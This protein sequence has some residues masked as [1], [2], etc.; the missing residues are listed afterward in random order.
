MP[1]PLLQDAALAWE[2]AGVCVL[3]A[4]ADG[5]KRP[6]LPWQQYQQRRASRDELA[7][8]FRG[9]EI[10]GIGLIC[11]QVS[12]GL[13][14]FEAEGAAVADGMH[15]A[16]R[17]LFVAAGLPDLWDKI[18]TYVEQSPAGGLHWIYRVDGTVPGNTK[19]ARRR[20]DGAVQVLFET[21][22][23]GGWVVCSP[24]AGRTHPTGKAWQILPGSTPGVIPTLTVDEHQTLHRLAM[25]FDV[26]ETFVAPVEPPASLRT[27][28]EKAP[29]DQ[30]NETTDWADILIP[31]GWTLVYTRGD[32]TRA[33][34]RPG[35]RVGISATTGFGDQGLDLLYVFTSSTQFDQE[36]SYSKLGAY[37]VLNTGGDFAK[38]ASELRRQGF[39]DPLPPQERTNPLTLIYGEGQGG[40]ASPPSAP[41]SP[42]TP[43][44]V[45]GQQPDEDEPA[46]AELD[47]SVH[48]DGTFVPL[49]PELMRRSDD[50]HLL[51]RGKVHSFHGESESGKSWIGLHAIAE[52]LKAGSRAAMIDFE[53][54][55]HTIVGRL[56][57]MGVE[58]EA[59]RTLFSYRHPDVNP[60]GSAREFQ[61][62]EKLLT[63]RY[64]IVLIDGITEALNVF[65]VTSKDNDEVTGW[66]RSVPRKLAWSTGAAVIM[67][68]HVT[69][70]ADSRGRFAIGAQ[71]KMT[72]LDGAAY[73]IE[74]LEPL[75]VGLI[76]RISMRVAKDRNGSIR[77]RSGPYR[78]GDHSQE[79]AVVTVNSAVDD[80]TT[81]R[82]DPPRMDTVDTPEGQRRPF[83]PTGLMERVSDRLVEMNCPM[84]RTSLKQM[85]QGKNEFV[86]QAIDFLIAD[87]YAAEDGPSVN[88]GKPTVRLIKPYRE[89]GDPS[90]DLDPADLVPDPLSETRPRPLSNDRGTGGTGSSRSET[91]PQGRVGD[92]LGTGS[93]QLPLDGVGG[94]L[95]A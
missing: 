5:S 51:Y 68:D 35:K 70:D 87:G 67:V 57:R 73:M 27:P 56:L 54:D 46:W 6:A 36:R 86:L 11:G 66:I 26:A 69:K 95:N 61:Q 60:F 25:T 80:V 8:W 7:N 29:G 13:E 34:R 81:V 33:W 17:D 42:Q 44:E 9:S 15:L 28:G 82:V 18:N 3:P 94:D 2:Q 55:A 50:F 1:V 10:E 52:Q 72:T 85:V 90:P 78:K 40:P 58:P 22:G 53:S 16:L 83:R 31:A 75:G 14:M 71:A 12:G 38:A 89:A 92:G 48:L 23:E 37:A 93:E 45:T 77:P 88:G 76:G 62:W 19:L 39:G 91:R 4:A 24:S 21:R 49:V 30:Y 65:S 63:G 41:W 59:I 64:E 32:G 43:S 79:A 47:L 74:V 20:V 84:S